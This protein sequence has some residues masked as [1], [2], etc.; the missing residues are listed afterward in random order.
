MKFLGAG[1]LL[2]AHTPHANAFAIVCCGVTAAIR[3]I[4]N[5]VTPRKHYVH[6]ACV[7]CEK[8]CAFVLKS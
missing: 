6:K 2:S 3:A 8:L 7:L 1:N 4:F 5:T